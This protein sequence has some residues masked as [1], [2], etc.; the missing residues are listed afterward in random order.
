MRRDAKRTSRCGLRLDSRREERADRNHMTSSLGKTPRTVVS[1]VPELLVATRIAATS[2]Q[3]GVESVN[4]RAEDAVE[5][6]RG[7]HVDLILIDLEAVADADRLIRALKSDP[8]TSAVPLACF[9]PH[10][11]NALRESALA[12]G[13][14]LVLPRSA[15]FRQLPALLGGERGTPA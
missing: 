6:C 1:I 4:A 11:R 2:K 10:V 15:F 5:I 12:V 7:L 14:D 9:C 13:A 3:L 8:A